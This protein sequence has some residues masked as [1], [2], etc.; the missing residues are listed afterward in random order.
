MN[1]LTSEL[2]LPGWGASYKKDELK[3]LLNLLPIQKEYSLLFQAFCGLYYFNI[4]IFM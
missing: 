4:P 3:A 2:S 1:P